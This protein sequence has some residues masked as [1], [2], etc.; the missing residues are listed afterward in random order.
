MKK[1][2]AL[3]LIIL[4]VGSWCL[5]A[6]ESEAS[7]LGPIAGAIAG[8]ALLIVVIWALVANSVA[9]APKDDSQPSLASS[10]EPSFAHTT[11]KPSKTGTQPIGK[12][13]NNPMLKHTMFGV[14]EDAVFIGARFSF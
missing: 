13:L 7:G 8:V 5:Y 11:V 1:K 3:F 4:M 6:E 14:A 12:V 2:I 9:E 10:D